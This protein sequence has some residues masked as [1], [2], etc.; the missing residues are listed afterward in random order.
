MLLRT[1]TNLTS[2]AEPDPNPDPSDPYVLGPPGFGSI[3]QRCGSESFYH[4]ADLVRKTLIP[5]VL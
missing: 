5:T 3:G 2:V 4:Q 1:R